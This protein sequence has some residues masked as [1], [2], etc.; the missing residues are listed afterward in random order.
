MSETHDHL[1][2]SARR[3]AETALD[4]YSDSAGPDDSD[5]AIHHMAVAI[6][7]LC[8]SYLASIDEALLMP[9]E[10]LTDANRLALSDSKT[11]HKPHTIGGKIAMERAETRLGKPFQRS[12]DLVALRDNRN[13]LTHMGSATPSDCRQLLTAGILCVEQLLPAMSRT[14]ESFWGPH[15]ALSEQIV[16]TSIG[17][18]QLRYDMKIRKAR[19]AGSDFTHRLDST[20]DREAL[21]AS[22]ASAEIWGL[23]L[24]MTCPACNSQGSVRGR[25]WTSGD[26][27]DGEW[28]LPRQ[29]TCLPCGLDLSRDELELAGMTMER[30]SD[31]EQDPGWEPDTA[32]FD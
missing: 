3:W 27:H 24:P 20:P 32:P 15:H 28:F 2:N 14:S 6:E 21:K 12:D 25:E 18:Q 4:S 9:N 17:E 16:E 13:G 1:F 8:K 5:F 7:H 22:L 10:R 31:Y 19:K 30:F 29:F 23:S 11:R 26:P